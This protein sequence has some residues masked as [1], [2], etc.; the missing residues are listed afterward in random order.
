LNHPPDLGKRIV[1]HNSS[2]GLCG[3]SRT[4]F[5]GF[6]RCWVS[7]PPPELILGSQSRA[8]LGHC[9]HW[10]WHRRSCHWCSGTEVGRSSNRIKFSLFWQWLVRTKWY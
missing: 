2:C 3:P 7:P 5:R 4:G 6:L 9:G 8:K 10:T 1:W